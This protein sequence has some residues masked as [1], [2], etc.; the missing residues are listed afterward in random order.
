MKT[1]ALVTI[2]TL[3]MVL[4]SACN[5]SAKSSA[6]GLVEHE[7]T[8]QKL[9][10]GFVFTEG[11]ATDKQGNIYFTDIPNSR[12]H[13]VSAEGN[14]STF[15]ENSGQANGLYFD[16]NGDL[17]ACA[18]GTRKLVS[19][20]EDKDVT[21][22]AEKYGGK[23][24]NSPNDLYLHA[25][26]GIYFTDPR[27]GSRENL[28][29]DGEH[30]YF[31]SSDRRRLIRVIDDMVRPNGVIGTSDGKRLYVADHGANK[32]YVY[33]IRPDGTLSEKK[34]FAMQG[35]DGM[36]VD[37]KGNV[38]LTEKAVS[39]FDPGGVMIKTIEVPERPS[40][41]CFGGKDKKTLFITAGTSLYS[42]RMR[43]KG[44]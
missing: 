26:G 40:N 35:S 19:I 42:I 44:Q 29:Q 11:P 8:V 15:L 37:H 5:Q 10:G 38:Y 25:K 23:S 33:K 22:L 30:V 32:T 16:K 13:R 27:Y 43:V 1:E 39:V 24:F 2:L 34:L 4:I 3:F 17:I 9:A 41:V 14:L 31:L 12:I 18:G 21:V 28:P 36:T 20:D 7:A 6:G